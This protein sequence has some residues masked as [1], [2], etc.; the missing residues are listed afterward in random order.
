MN[1]KPNLYGLLLA[2]KA[3]YPKYSDLCNEYIQKLISIPNYREIKPSYQFF[4]KDFN[5]PFNSYYELTWNIDEARRIIKAN[6]LD[7]SKIKIKDLVD[8]ATIN[9]VHPE[10]FESSLKD[11][12]PIIVAIIPHIDP[13][14]VIIDG[15]HRVNS[16]IYSNIHEISGYMLEPKLHHQALVSLVDKRY[17][18]IHF[19]LAMIDKCKDKNP[20][21]LLI[22]VP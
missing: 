8:S 18:A 12:S 20:T 5:L 7:S 9:S 13:P 10:K 1:K 22:E 4:S 3:K 17:H 2:F 6:K 21:P 16:R 11:Y 15:N 14:Y 19:N